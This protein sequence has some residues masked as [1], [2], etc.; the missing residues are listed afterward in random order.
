MMRTLLRAILV[1]VILVAAAGFLLGWW[2]GSRLHPGSRRPAV[3]TTG[4][5]PGPSGVDTSRAREGE[6]KIGEKTAIAAAKDEEV[7][8]DGA[9]TAKIKSKMALDDSVQARRIDVST[10]HGIVTVSGTVRSR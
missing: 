6:A 8:S 1:L 4:K 9:V 5:P 7:I 2:A 10:D 3:A